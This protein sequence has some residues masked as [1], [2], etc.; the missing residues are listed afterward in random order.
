MV[1]AVNKADSAKQDEVIYEFYSLGIGEPIPV[2]AA[3]H[4]NLGD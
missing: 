3:N 1:L 4:I 2:S